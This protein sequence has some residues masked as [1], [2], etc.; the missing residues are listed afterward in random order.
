MKPTTQTKQV[1]VL[2]LLLAF[3]VIYYF[4][5]GKKSLTPAP[6]IHPG[7]PPAAAAQAASAQAGAPTTAATTA[8]AGTD[9]SWVNAVR[10]NGIVHDVSVGH[11]PFTD[12]LAVADAAPTSTTPLTSSTNII[13]KKGDQKGILPT[14]PGP[15]GPRPMP[16]PMP[17]A[18]PPPTFALNGI[19]TSRNTRFAAI[20]VN[21]QYYTLV[22]GEMIP[23]LGWLLKKISP[24]FN[25]VLLTKNGA[26]PVTLRL[27]GG[28]QK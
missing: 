28:T 24:H 16:M 8:D 13:P 4:V 2:A 14:G 25:T 18:L 15:I 3:G 6:A 21:G 7:A 5:W 12:S 9:T 26:Q 19:I 17:V 22:E 11:N 20:A 27:A 10:L 1:I 23:K